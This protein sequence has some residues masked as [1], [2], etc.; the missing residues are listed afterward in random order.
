M[1]TLVTAD[2][3]VGHRVDGGSPRAIDQRHGVLLDVLGIG[4]LVVGKSGIGKS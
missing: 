2:F 3:C 1:S 4:V